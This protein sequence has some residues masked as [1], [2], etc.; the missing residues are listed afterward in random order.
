MKPDHISFLL[1]PLLL[2]MSAFT[3]HG[4][5]RSGLTVYDEAGIPF[6]MSLDGKQKNPSE[7]KARLSLD[8][9]PSGEHEVRISYP[10]T[11][12]PT[13]EKQIQLQAF[14]SYT[15]VLQASDGAKRS[16]SLISR[17]KTEGKVQKDPEEE[18]DVE[19]MT[20]EGPDIPETDSSFIRSYKGKSAC[21]DPVRKGNFEQVHRKVKDA[22]F[23]KKRLSIAKNWIEQHCVLS[24]HVAALMGT[25]DYEENRLDLA[26]YAYG[27]TFD[28]SNYQVVLEALNF[29]RSR[30]D[31]HRYLRE[32][33]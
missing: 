27:R 14:V 29:K 31:L 13:F 5:G 11:A 15:Y 28:Q 16:W 1:P 9:I 25:L 19:M 12:I 4:Q 3:L 22:I 10:D 7:A 30:E 21:T 33:Q 8:S 26:K 32:F 24:S 17:V 20:S 2:L 18:A 6:H 23:Q